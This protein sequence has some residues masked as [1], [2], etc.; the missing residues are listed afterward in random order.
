M[1]DFQDDIKSMDIQSLSQALINHNLTPTQLVKTIFARL[2]K[3]QDHHIWVSHFNEEDC[4]KRASYLESLS[5]TERKKKP[6][7]A[8]AFAVKD[9]IDVEGLPTTAGCP[10]YTYH[11]QSN[12][13]VVTLLLE[14]GAICIGKT[15][16]DQFA[17][18]LVGVRSPYGIVR[19][20]FNETY[21]SGGSSSGSAVAVALGL[22]SFSLGSDTAGSG[23]VPASF[24]NIIGLKPTRGLLSTQG[25]VPACRSLDCL[26]IFALTIDDAMTVLRYSEGF[27]TS[28]SFSRKRKILPLSPRKP[29][30]FAVP[31]NLDET[32]FADQESLSLYQEAIKK[33][34]SLGW[35]KI[36]YDYSPFQECAALL[37]E[38]PWISERSSA[39]GDFIKKNPKE[40]MPIT[41]KIIENGYSKSAIDY[42]KASYRLQEIIKKTKSLWEKTDVLMLPTT[43][44]I[45]TISDIE[46]DPITTNSHLGLHTNFTNLLDLS[47]I[48][49]PFSFRKNAVPFGITL[50]APAFSESILSILGAEF[51]QATDL[52]LGATPY[53]VPRQNPKAHCDDQLLPLLVVGGHL[54]GQALNHQLTNKGALLLETVTTSPSYRLYDLPGHP[55]RPG[56]IRVDQEGHSIEGEIWGLTP[57]DFGEFIASIPSPLGVGKVELSDGRKV[58]G[59]LCESQAIPGTQDISSFGGWRSWRASLA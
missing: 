46:S 42:F 3:T 48:A 27:D 47:A 17:T 10:A 31:E 39:V 2:R 32:F 11:P 4:L 43:G 21:C 13:R 19:N 40:V 50:M 15:N 24:N 59:F 52:P 12:A 26:S 34:E 55:P 16:L 25:L 51:H 29:V 6:L 7:W 22:V 58:T 20:P 56:M 1:I 41:A 8:I 37:Y 57:S 49:I 28:D 18:G 30:T 33:A 36:Y 5:A 54:S 44:T 53:P 35:T 14:A 9:N 23:R 45:Y 38:G